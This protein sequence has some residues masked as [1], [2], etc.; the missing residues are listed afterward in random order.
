M[1]KANYN[2]MMEDRISGM[3]DYDKNRENYEQRKESG[4]Y[5]ANME[6]NKENDVE[7]GAWVLITRQIPVEERCKPHLFGIYWGIP[8]QDSYDRQVCVIHTTEDV[9]LLNHEFTVIDDERLRIYREEGWELHENN[10]AVDIGLNTEI[11][12]RGRVLCE[13]ERE[14]IWALQLDG[15]TE[16]QACEEYFFTKHTDYNNFSICYIPNKE[17]FAQC[18]AVFGE[19]YGKGRLKH[20]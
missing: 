7:S 12:E 19:R 20:G 4:D 13:E 2:K 5:D 14:V 3:K 1:G 11:I 15:L 8:K 10:A 6:Y 16:T 17:V 18:I 9:T